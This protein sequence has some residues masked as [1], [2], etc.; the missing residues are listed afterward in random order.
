VTVASVPRTLP[1][2]RKVAVVTGATSGLGREIAIGFA[3]RGARTVVVGRGVD[4]AAQAASEI[5]LEAENPLV[6]SVPVRD[7]A[8]RS[9]VQALAQTLQARY[10]AISFLVN[11]AGGYFHRRQTTSEGIERT[12]ALNV[13]A[14]FLLTSL[15]V[16]RLKAGAPARVVNVASAAHERQT[17]DF[18]DLQGARRY[19]GHRAYG[20][21][22][23]AL[24]LLTREMARRLGDSGVT[25]TA[26]HPGFV[27]TGLGQQDAGILALAFR[28]GFL[29]GKTPRQGATTPLYAA[30]DPS[31]A[32]ANGVYFV[33]GRIALGSLASRDE[34]SAR[35]LYDV[36]RQLTGAPEIAQREIPPMGAS[37]PE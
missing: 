1:L 37:P 30:T 33:N 18:R 26:V 34:E 12:F 19:F 2:A 5:A 10:P 27:R 6:E 9:E 32:E 36:C 22:K 13:L 20:R 14:P 24:I 11:N 25:V 21:S 4:R 23:L 15:L 31:V 3:R 16:P 8:L 17:L 28:L 7:L 35:R 29:L